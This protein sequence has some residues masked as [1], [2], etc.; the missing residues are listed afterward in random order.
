MIN[1]LILT[2]VIATII[3][4]VSWKT[5]R[6][7]AKIK[8][9]EHAFENGDLQTTSAIVNEILETHGDNVP[10]KYIKAKLLIRQNQYVQAIF[11]LN[12]VLSM[13]DYR[14]YIEEL[15]IRTN[16]ALLYHETQDYGKEIDEYKFISHLDPKNIIANERLGHAMFTKKNYKSALDYLLK[17]DELVEHHDCLTMIGISYY[18]LNEHEHAETYL[19]RA[20]NDNAENNEARY[21][22]GS[23]NFARR[24]YTD[25]LQFLELSKKD[26][27]YFV[28]SVLLLGTIYCEKNNYEQAITILESGL[29]SLKDRAEEAAEYRYLLASA[30]EAV[31]RIKEATYHWEKISLDTPGYRDVRDK[32]DSYRTVMSDPDLAELFSTS[33]DENQILI[34]EIIALLQ[35]SVQSSEK[36]SNNE[37]HYKVS[38]VKRPNE[39]PTLIV[40]LKTTRDLNE[41]HIA[42]FQRKVSVDKYKSGIFITTGTFNARARASTASKKEIDL[43]DVDSLL[44]LIERA[45]LKMNKG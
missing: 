34:K 17:V 7:S 19:F 3:A 29:K 39:P 40:Y 42:D 14:N 8:R 38:N 11:E 32:L 22:L 18:M 10:T 35:Y 31:G 44:R 27:R 9:A 2:F 45:K 28:K 36:I 24:A 6:L 12:S 5:N 37:Y 21:Y 13:A 43:I 4:L 33:I 41:S 26:K 1:F 23:I 15:D 16:L 30:Y 25:A 20:I